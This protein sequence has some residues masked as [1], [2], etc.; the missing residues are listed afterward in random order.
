MPPT[1]EVPP[2][3]PDGGEM[4]AIALDDVSRYKKSERKHEIEA[5]SPESIPAFSSQ[6]YNCT[7][8]ARIDTLIFRL[9]P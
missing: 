9:N 2:F 1:S 3:I 6:D 4:E 5:H 7:A 8:I